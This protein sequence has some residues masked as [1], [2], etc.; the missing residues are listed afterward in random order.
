MNY[1]KKETTDKKY[2]LTS[3]KTRRHAR[4]SLFLYKYILILAVA[5]TFVMVGLGFGFVRGILNN[6]PRLS[7]DSIHKTSY[8]TVIYNNKNQRI[9]SIEN[10]DVKKN[11]QKLSTLPNNLQ[12]AFVAIEDKDF[13]SHSG[14]DIY[15]V[16]KGIILNVQNKSNHVNSTIT[17]QLVENSILGNEYKGSTIERIESQIQEQY[18][19][20]KLEKMSSKQTILEQY[21]NTINLG[22]GTTGVQ[23]ASKKYFNKDAKSLTLSESTVLAALAG[24]PSKYDPFKHPDAN[25]SKRLLVLQNMLEQHYITKTEYSEALNDNIYNKL[26]DTVNSSNS[27]LLGNSDFNNALLLQ[28]VEDLQN[29]LGYDESTAYAAIY[30]GGL[31]IYSTQ[32]SQIQKIAENI[33]E[34]ASNYPA[35]SEYKLTYYLIT[36][37]KHKKEHVYT[38]KNVLT[39][40]KKQKIGSS[41]SFSSQT[42]AKKTTAQFKAFLKKKGE[43]KVSEDFHLSIQPQIS[44]S[45]LNQYNGS[46]EAL[47]GGRGK[48]STSNSDRS[49][50]NTEQPGT[51]FAILSAF[52][53]ALDQNRLT[54]AS[55]F[56]DA[57][58]R[59]LD[60]NEAVKNDAAAYQ[61]LT[62]IRNAITNSVN[63]VAAKVMSEVTPT[64]SYQYLNDLGFSTLSDTQSV[65][66]GK[67]SSDIHQA[68]A[69]GELTS[70]VTNLEMTNAYATIANGGSYHTPHFYTKVVDRYGR[71][72]LKNKESSKQVIQRSTAFLLTDALEDSISKGTSSSAKLSNNITCAGSSGTRLES[73]DAWFSGYT[74]Y[75]T[76]SVWMGYDTD[77]KF[78]S[79][80]CQSK[81]W[82]KI[83]DKITSTKKEKNIS[84][85]KPSNI[86][87]GK[88]CTKSGKLEIPGV[89][90]E[91]PRGDLTK[92]EFFTVGTVPTQ[93]CDVH[94]K[95]TFCKET[96]EIATSGCPSTYDKVYL[97][98]SSYNKGKTADTPYELPK[99]QK[100]C[101]KHQAEETQ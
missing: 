16:A 19:S 2:A 37:D 54:L 17:S 82:K 27:T 46:V 101:T 93:T 61:G 7:L 62:T 100:K 15:N 14:I 83:M 51:D 75:H 22:E 88:I 70:G 6:A 84:F 36:K 68:L 50:L 11:Y 57:P 56:D 95:V 65:N 53:P 20:Y 81:I 71:V 18:L 55:S 33:S 9:G 31:K 96:N 23:A 26:K 98:H 13:Y 30:S 32:D 12:N 25:A 41:L 3:S 39:Y 8:R 79:E 87:T 52:L 43:S 42:A 99:N 73:D 85:V 58:Y 5:I 77:T 64:T 89:C 44:I 59:Y 49:V 24:N 60:N 28:V 94:T 63:V 29:Q 97:L 35:T 76:A 1:N 69:L 47:I 34:D 86:T 66:K 78:S 48:D 67:A 80:N 4:Y 40:M 45:I 38:E 90:S 91:D 72:L 92:T 74:P 10:T 21:L